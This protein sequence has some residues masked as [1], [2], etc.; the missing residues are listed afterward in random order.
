MSSE[1][2]FGKYRGTVFNNID[3]EQRGRMMVMVPDVLGG[4]PSNW[5][6]ACVPYIALPGQSMDKLILPSVG[7]AV[8]VEFERGDPDFPIWVGC[9]WV[10]PSAEN[11]I[12]DGGVTTSANI[13]IQSMGQHSITISDLP[14]AT[15]GI[16][17]K[18]P[19]GASIILN[20]DGIYLQ[21]GRGA[22]L[23]M[24][25]PSVI[26]NNGALAIT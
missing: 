11:P 22:S 3:P 14:G 24:V 2:Y 25:G 17:L 13:L 7:A 1:K 8:W 23:I 21:N 26:I 4:N 20:D 6:E 19:N 9:Q 10:I 15:G 18:S 16:M 12:A 5:A